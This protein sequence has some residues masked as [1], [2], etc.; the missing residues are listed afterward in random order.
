MLSG[1]RALRAVLELLAWRMRLNKFK[2]LSLNAA[3]ATPASTQQPSH[4]H[5]HSRFEQHGFFAAGT[6][7]THQPTKRRELA[8][9]E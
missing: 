4:S 9:R 8:K 5:M 3:S 2:T 1:R 6:L 7:D